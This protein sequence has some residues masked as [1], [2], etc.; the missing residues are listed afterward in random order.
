[1]GRST[2]VVS[3]LT[4]SIECKLISILTSSVKYL[5][6]RLEE[7]LSRDTCSPI[8][9]DLISFIK[10]CMAM[11]GLFSTS[12]GNLLGVRPNWEIKSGFE[13]NS[14]RTT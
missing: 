11:I 6:Y 14:V 2:I 1:M 4:T 13:S 8:L 10:T 3:R 7:E 12:S 9:S 5:R